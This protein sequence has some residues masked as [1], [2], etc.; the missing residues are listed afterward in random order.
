[1][2]NTNQ[3]TP[4]QLKKLKLYF[5]KLKDSIKR[6]NKLKEFMKESVLKPK[7]LNPINLQEEIYNII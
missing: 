4:S 1:L 3:I 2:N 7:K 5:N 6:K